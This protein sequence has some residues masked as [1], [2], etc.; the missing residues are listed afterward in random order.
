MSDSHDDD[1]DAVWYAARQ[2]NPE[3][4]RRLIERGGNVNYYDLG[5]VR[6]PRMGARVAAAAC[7][8]CGSRSS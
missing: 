1:D 7:L 4:L 8:G 5:Y 6:M 3:K 2:N